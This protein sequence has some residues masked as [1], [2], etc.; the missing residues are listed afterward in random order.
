MMEKE[1]IITR[2]EEVL[3]KRFEKREKPLSIKCEYPEP[4]SFNDLRFDKWRKNK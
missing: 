4:K 2:F 1:E 3:N